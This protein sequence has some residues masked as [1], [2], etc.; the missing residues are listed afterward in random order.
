MTKP[1]VYLWQPQHPE[2]PCYV[3]VRSGGAGGLGWNRTDYHIYYFALEPSGPR[4]EPDEIYP[5]RTFS[6]GFE[7]DDEAYAYAMSLSLK[8]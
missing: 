4:Y 2:S 8:H 5:F 7:A 6:S 3:V 1:K